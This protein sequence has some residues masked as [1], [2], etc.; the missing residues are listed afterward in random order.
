ME[1]GNGIPGSED[2]NVINILG[3]ASHTH[4]Q[5]LSSMRHEHVGFTETLQTMG[6]VIKIQPDNKLIPI[7][8]LRI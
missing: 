8:P 7:K 5:R 2:I 6:A 3:T 4:L 1:N